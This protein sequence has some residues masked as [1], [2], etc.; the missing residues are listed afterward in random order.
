MNI[1]I[2]DVET[3]ISNKGNPFDLTNKCVM[4]GLK[5]ADGD[6]KIVGGGFDGLNNKVKR[7][8]IQKNIDN[9]YLLVG[10]NIKFD[11]HWLRK[12]GIDIS[13]I[14]V[15]DCQL[16]E[17]LLNFQKTPY[18]SLN[19]AAIKYGFPPKLDVVKSEYWD[20]GICT[21]EVPREILSAYL[22]QDLVL[23][24]QV[25][26]KQIEQ[27][28]SNGLYPLFKLQCAD[29]LVLE[30]IEWNGIKF[31]TEAARKKAV[32]IEKELDVIY[33]EVSEYVGGIPINLASND[34]VSCLLYGG[35]ISEDVRI[36]IGIYKSGQKVGQVRYK[37][38]TKEYELP[39]LVEPLKG[40]EVKKP[41]GRGEYWKVNDTV[42]RGLKINTEVKKILTLLK[43][44]SELEK[45]RGTYL[46]GYS[47]LIDK[48][49]W[50]KDTLHGTLNQC[51]AITG[52]IASTKPNLQNMNPIVKTFCESR[53]EN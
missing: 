19:D 10:F 37:I 29:L 22:E 11:L 35:S 7:D 26:E 45:L 47:N 5:Y 42:L 3:T 31:D 32:E 52:R 41:E 15:W 1:L 48:M 33:N 16:A 40:T 44:H 36:P 18:P 9:S 43:R 50:E 53:Y 12:I 46:I 30:D 21:S 28:K 27:F 24:Q 8:Y 38:L 39:R 49:N 23:T 14:K 6:S 4:V 34:H 25:Y 13:K 2:L 20:K 17:F 51:S